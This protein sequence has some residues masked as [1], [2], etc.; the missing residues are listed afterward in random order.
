MERDKVVRGLE[1]CGTDAAPIE[2]QGCPYETDVF[3]SCAGELMADALA[4]VK[5]LEMDLEVTRQNLGDCR[6]ALNR[7]ED[8]LAKV[9]KALKGTRVQLKHERFMRSRAESMLGGCGDM[10]EVEPVIHAHWIPMGMHPVGGRYLWY[11]SACGQHG[12]RDFERCPH[13]GA[14]MDEEAPD[15]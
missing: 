11:C 6:E 12:D 7:N 13:C 3:L 15:V 9:K 10:Y 2:C 14:H 8:E 5:Q 1:C 4:L